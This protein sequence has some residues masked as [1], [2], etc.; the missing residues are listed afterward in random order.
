MSA[1]RNELS[2]KIRQW[3]RDR[4]IIQNSNLLAQQLKLG[5]EVGE[6]ILGVRKN[7]KDLIIDSIGDTYVV[8]TIIMGLLDV[9]IEDLELYNNE[10]YEDSKNRKK[11]IYWIQDTSG[12]IAKYVLHN[13]KHNIINKVRDL[14]ND[15]EAIAIENNTNLDE[16]I[17]S[18]YNEIKDRKGYLREDGI[19]VK[20][21]DMKA[22]K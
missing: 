5:E 18:A 10:Y 7:Y 21:A 4:K 17:M 6:L 22:E 3:A 15:L 13:K 12:S 9:N 14:I 19:F 8:A 1:V 20:E 11:G 16:C 2:R